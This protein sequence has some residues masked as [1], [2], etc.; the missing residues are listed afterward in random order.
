M[1]E[2]AGSLD[3]VVFGRYRLRTLIGQGGMGNVYRAHGTVIGRN[4]ANKMLPPELGADRELSAA[5]SA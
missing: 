4:V 3:E 2:E 5:I 1:G